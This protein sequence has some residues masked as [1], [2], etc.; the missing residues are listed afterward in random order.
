MP[1]GRGRLTRAYAQRCATTILSSPRGFH[2]GA[3]PCTDLS[4]QPGTD[5]SLQPRRSREADALSA[6]SVAVSLRSSSGG[7][8]EFGVRPALVA[9]C[10]CDLACYLEEAS[11]ESAVQAA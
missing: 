1:L 4:S 10:G 7:L 8:L 6:I 5:P 3:R 2:L 11:A 9:Y